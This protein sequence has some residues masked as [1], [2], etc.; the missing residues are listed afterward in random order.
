METDYI[1]FNKIMKREK[2]G[3]EASGMIRSANRRYMRKGVS[4]DGAKGIN[5]SNQQLS[6]L[7]S[8]FD[9]QNNRYSDQGGKLLGGKIN[10]KMP[11]YDTP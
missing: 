11:F 5:Q 6:E 9:L 7:V 8:Q 2:M 1:I 4:S 10:K 3:R